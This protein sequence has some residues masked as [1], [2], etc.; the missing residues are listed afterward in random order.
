M[1]SQQVEVWGNGELLDTWEMS[2][3]SQLFKAVVPASL[4]EQGFLLINFIAL[5]SLV[6]PEV[7]TGKSK[8]KRKLGIGLIDFTLSRLQW[9]SEFGHLTTAEFSQQAKVVHGE[10]YDYSKVEYA[11]TRLP[12]VV[13]CPKHGQFKTKTSKHLKR[14]C[15]PTSG[16]ASLPRAI[17]GHASQIEVLMD[18][19][20]K[21]RCWK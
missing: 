1:S 19:Y 5:G 13:I 8:D 15:S 20:C 11:G 2:S 21:R 18:G 6:S 3:K 14:V 12:V 17:N 4:I 10:K 7:R 16:W 9:Y